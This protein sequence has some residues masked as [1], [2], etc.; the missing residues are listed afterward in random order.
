MQRI[1]KNTWTICFWSGT[2]NNK[3]N[4]TKIK[5]NAVCVLTAVAQS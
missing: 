5:L 3:K 1:I 2:G 4:K